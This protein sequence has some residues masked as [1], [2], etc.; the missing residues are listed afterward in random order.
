MKLHTPRT[1][2]SF[3]CGKCDQKMVDSNRPETGSFFVQHGHAYDN[4]TKEFDGEYVGV[5]FAICTPCTQ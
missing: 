3:W 2:Q 4:E 5:M 1:P